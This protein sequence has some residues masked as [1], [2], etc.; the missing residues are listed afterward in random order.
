MIA[1]LHRFIGDGFRVF[2]LAMGVYALF[3][4]GF[5]LLWLFVHWAG[6]M[7]TSLPFAMAPHLWHGHELI[8]GYGAAALA[9]FLLTAVPNWTGTKAARHLFIGFAALVWLVGRGAVW[10]SAALPAWLVMVADLAF[11]PLLMLKIAAQLAKRPKPQNVMFLGLLAIIWASNLMVHLE[12]M[13]ILDDGAAPGLR[14][15]LYG[16]CAMIAV[17]GGRVTPAFTRNAMIREGYETGLPVSYRPL[18]LLGVAL[19]ILLPLAVMAQLPD[20]IIAAL[21]LAVGVVQV[22]RVA[23]WRPGFALRQPILW[24]L[25]VSFASIGIG[26]ILTGLALLGFGSEV[27]GFHVTAIAGV[28]G[29]TVAVAS[30]ATLG[31]TGRP[32]VAPR[33]VAMAYGLLPLAAVLRWT[34]SAWGG[35][36]YY[37]AVFAASIAWLAAYGCYTAALWPAFWGPRLTGKE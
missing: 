23:G 13:G 20:P 2:F 14:A 35:A 19:A 29:M 30:R 21:L 9:G 17:L 22:A 27:A 10:Y 28:A 34:A 8:F 7:F 3:A 24:S 31:H 25:H 18:E 12:W 4:L 11:V 5:W 15:G 1:M 6:G 36:A 37:P 33:V 16:Y 26:F 32:L